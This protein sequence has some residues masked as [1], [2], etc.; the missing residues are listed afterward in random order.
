MLPATIQPADAE[1][2]PAD[3]A[4]LLAP[5]PD[6]G[7]AWVAEIETRALA[8]LSAVMSALVNHAGWPTAEA[9]DFN[10]KAPKRR[11]RFYVA[12]TG[13]W[14]EGE[15]LAAQQR[16][17]GLISLIA[18]ITALPR[19]ASA[20]ALAVI[21]TRAGV[22][23]DERPV[24][25]AVEVSEYRDLRKVMDRRR[26]DLGM[27]MEE[28]DHRSGVASGYSAKILGGVRCLGPL[29]LPCLLG[30]LRLRMTLA[31]VEAA[32]TATINQP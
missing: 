16:G 26:K 11:F 5:K 17:D 1:P 9:R 22:P 3:S 20:D 2:A 10:R 21:L 28:L 4:G 12:D 24:T 8:N 14:I 6:P 29:S 15:D 7:A 27:S 13:G 18:C 30:A 23:V 31:P 32:S 19:D 25:T